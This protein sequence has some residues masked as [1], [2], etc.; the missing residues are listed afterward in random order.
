MKKEFTKSKKPIKA[1]EGAVLQ[2][3]QPEQMEEYQAPVNEESSEI[4]CE[5]IVSMLLESRTQA[6]IWHLSTSSFAEHVALQSY[7]DDVVELIDTFVEQ[8]Q[9]RFGIIRQYDTL[10]KIEY[11]KR[12]I[13]DYFTYI[14]EVSEVHAETL[15]GHLK[16]V[17]EEIIGLIYQTI[18]KLRELS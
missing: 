8:Y 17:L 1:Q 13:L 7:Y 16:N 4:S 12:D 10:D 15:P 11:N 3:A 5:Q 18:Y 6:H 2:Q 14:A 9:G